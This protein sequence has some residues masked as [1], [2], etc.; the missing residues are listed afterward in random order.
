MESPR[1]GCLCCRNCCRKNTVIN[2]NMNGNENSNISIS[3]NTYKQNNINHISFFE[4]LKR[5]FNRNNNNNFRE[6]Y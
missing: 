1:C 3:E 2:Y 6:S 4:R 5:L